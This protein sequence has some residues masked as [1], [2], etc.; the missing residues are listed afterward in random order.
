MELRLENNS[1]SGEIPTLVL[2]S[3]F[4]HK[5]SAMDPIP[6]SRTR[7]LAFLEWFE[8]QRNQ[9]TGYIC[10]L[11]NP[12]LCGASSEETAC[13]RTGAQNCMQIL[14]SVIFEQ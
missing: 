5:L 14:L 9:L 13:S 10:S 2:V 8:T 6:S 7:S 4:H 3:L 1:L 11:S 12:H